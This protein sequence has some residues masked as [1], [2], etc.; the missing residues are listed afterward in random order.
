M[1]IAPRRISGGETIP[2]GLRRRGVQLRAGVVIALNKPFGHESNSEVD[3]P[4]GLEGYLLQVTQTLPRGK[5]ASPHVDL[6]H[7]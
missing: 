3:I 7:F 2:K 4:K 1:F 5:K 6:I